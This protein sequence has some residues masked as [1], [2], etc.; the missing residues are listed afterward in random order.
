M[1]DAGISASPM[2]YAEKNEGAEYDDG[3]E[4]PAEQ[5]MQTI[6]ARDQAAAGAAAVTASS[7]SESEEDS[8]KPIQTQ[9]DKANHFLLVEV[10][11]TV[12]SFDMS[13]LGLTSI[14]TLPVVYWPIAAIWGLEVYNDY[15]GN[16]TPLTPKLSWKSFYPP[17]TEME[18]PLPNQPLWIAWLSYVILLTCL[19]IIWMGIISLICYVIYDPSG[20]LSGL[21]QLLPFFKSV[22]GV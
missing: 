20:A 4:I 15:T 21:G 16:S 14:V 1:E 17:G 2:A 5:R 22:I 19:S 10:L 12:I 18:V 3:G 11:P 13:C 9:L 8:K 6:L 7:A